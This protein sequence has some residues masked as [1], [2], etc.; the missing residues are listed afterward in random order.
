MYQL[1]LALVIVLCLSTV[2]AWRGKPAPQGGREDLRVDPRDLMIGDLQF[3]EEETRDWSSNGEVQ[4]VDRI[5]FKESGSDGGSSSKIPNITPHPV[6][7]FLFDSEEKTW[8]EASVKKEE[9]Q[10]CV[11]SGCH[12]TVTLTKPLLGYDLLKQSGCGGEGQ[13]KKQ[14]FTEG[15]WEEV[16]EE[17]EDAR[18][19]C[20]MTSISSNQ[21]S[22][23]SI[24]PEG[25][26]TREINWFGRENREGISPG[27]ST[28][29]PRSPG[30]T[31]V[32][33]SKRTIGNDRKFVCRVIYSHMGYGTNLGNSVP[34]AD[35]KVFYK[36]IQGAK[37][38]SYLLDLGW[39]GF[40]AGQN[41]FVPIKF[42]SLLRICL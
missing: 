31:V 28:R 16:E 12:T 20:Y 7:L 32:Y 29:V 24:F 25:C 22:T 3:K 19:P 11:K 30:N 38:G 4:I 21:Q 35:V 10:V 8:E 23:A 27:G 41:R 6:A 26:A 40:F 17:E 5:E 34:A 13:F 14:P 15:R 18:P 36:P 2:S 42:Q 39:R 33:F 37:W 9:K 1:R